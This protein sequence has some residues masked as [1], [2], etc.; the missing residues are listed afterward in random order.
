MLGK[1]RGEAAGQ[2]VLKRAGRKGDGQKVARPAYAGR[3]HAA[4]FERIAGAESGDRAVERAR[5]GDH[6]LGV[7]SEG[8][9]LAAADGALQ[10]HRRAGGDRERAGAGDIAVDQQV[11]AVRHDRAVVVDGRGPHR[12]VAAEVARQRA[13]A[14]NQAAVRDVDGRGANGGVGAA[15]VDRAV[16]VDGERPEQRQQG[17]VARAF[18]D[19]DDA[20]AGAADRGVAVHQDG[21]V[22]ADGDVALSADRAADREPAGV[23]CGACRRRASGRRCRPRRPPGCSRRR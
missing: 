2:G 1:A 12:L 22:A 15:E 11:A 10:C 9:R 8:E 19:R 18:A 17:N 14:G 7:R 21:A 16:A 6:Q 3:L 5:I 13:G 23:R 4:D 20:G